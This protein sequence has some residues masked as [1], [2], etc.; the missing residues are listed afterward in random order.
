MTSIFVEIIKI[1]SLRDVIYMLLI[2]H[3]I[4]F[5]PRTKLVFYDAVNLPNFPP[6]EHDKFITREI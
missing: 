4:P 1:L 5:D 3:K 2:L 6:K